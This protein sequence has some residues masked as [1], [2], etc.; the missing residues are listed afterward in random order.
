MKKRNPFYLRATEQITDDLYFFKYFSPEVLDLFGDIDSKIWNKPLVIRSSPGGGKSS[1]FRA[2]SIELLSKIIKHKDSGEDYRYF[3]KRME[4]L[5]VTKDKKIKVFGLILSCARNY[6]ILDDYGFEKSIAERL[7][8]ALMNARILLSVLRH[9]AS[10]HK[11]DFPDGLAQIKF[12]L[13]SMDEDL[14]YELKKK[15]IKSRVDGKVVYEWAIQTE[16]KIFNHLDSTIFSNSVEE[17]N[18]PEG[19][20]SFFAFSLL[21]E[22]NIFVREEE[23][24]YK[25]LLMFDDV[26]KLTKNQRKILREALMDIRPSLSIWL[27]ERTEAISPEELFALG[28][29]EGRDYNETVNLEERWSTANFTKVT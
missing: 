4:Q 11:I 27:A 26:Q 22:R 14:P 15:N 2:F 17:T 20:S 9:M 12:N 16:R 24:E 3:F 28:S 7:F 5:G 21:K 18:L 10:V 19:N 6:S 25:Y 8:I 1:L 23:L 29:I 13:N